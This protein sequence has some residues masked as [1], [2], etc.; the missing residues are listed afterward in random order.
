[1]S[2]PRLD[3]LEARETP[4]AY[5]LADLIPH[6]DAGW[7]R[8]MPDVPAASVLVSGADLDGPAVPGGIVDVFAAHGSG[9]AARV[10]VRDTQ[11]GDTLADFFAFEEAF[12]GGVNRVAVIGS[13]LFV[14]PGSG[15]G[16]VVAAID[17]G[18][19]AV[20]HTFAPG[21]AADYRGGID[22]LTTADLDWVD[23][24]GT[25]DPEQ[26]LLILC[27]PVVTYAE[28]D[29]TPRLSP[30]YAFS[31]DDTRPWE[32]VPATAGVQV[33]GSLLPGFS[34][35]PADSRPDDTGRVAETR[36][37]TFAGALA[38][39]DRDFDFAPIEV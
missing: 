28:P 20:T 4:A 32:F 23:G 36:T 26:E 37:L 8:P 30:V 22:D 21:V 11:T 2:R 13:T 7:V 1:M 38:P 18:T 19:K 39:S 9:N 15:G 6:Y 10:V 29:G 5:T 34:V 16:P 31:P 25:P 27:G 17:L 33:P 12:R 24:T 14:A 35:Q 3:P